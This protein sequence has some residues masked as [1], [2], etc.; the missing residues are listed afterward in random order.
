MW[1]CLILTSLVLLIAGGVV[2]VYLAW[3]YFVNEGEEAVS[4]PTSTPATPTAPTPTPTPR[5]TATPIPTPTP[6]PFPL[7]PG[8]QSPATDRE[9]LVRLYEA[10]D[11]PNWTDNRNWLS[12]A[13]L[14][15][16][17]GVDTDSDDRVTLLYL[18][19]NNLN[20][21]V[22][23]NLLNMGRLDS[24]LLEGNP[25]SGCISE[26]LQAAVYDDDLHT[27]G[28][29]MCSVVPTPV[30]S[31]TPI[32]TPT[33]VP[34]ATPIPTPTPVPTPTPIPTPKPTSTPVPTATPRPCSD[35]IECLRAHA[36][37]LINDDRARYGLQ[38]VALGSNIAAQLHAQDMVEH[39]YIGHW[40][41]DGRKPYMVYTQTGG[42]SYASENAAFSGWTDHRWEAQNCDSSRV[43]CNRGDTKQ[44]ITEHQWGMMYDDAHADWGHRDNILRESH[45]A[46]NI[47]IFWN[48]KRIAFV[49][50]FEGGAVTALSG[51]A[52]SRNGIFSLELVK[53]EQ[54]IHIGQGVSVYYD[55]PPT[56][57][58][59][60]QID[61]LDS[62]C[63]GGG[64]T[65][66]C[67]DP[68]IR[69]LRPP[70]ANRYYSNLDDNEVVAD[71]W[72][73]TDNSFSFSVDVSDL[74]QKPGVYTVIVWRDSGGSLLSEQ[75]I[76]LSVFV[77]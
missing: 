54:G 67:G 61:V 75:L 42:T 60:A 6:L 7:P 12:D 36:L 69:I 76:E 19:D 9:A 1:R 32:P 65:T 29:P 26:E 64:Q 33:P 72:T 35:D 56:R 14:V 77:R 5:P 40:W 21:V 46:V 28:L 22:P 39:G 2:G 45:R 27:L 70:G 59:V 24:L 47:G 68:V 52:L 43:R 18:I 17:Y 66:R 62:Y 71:S 13:P 48:K 37:R 8:V 31:P 49:Q 57:M 38:P 74:V 4:S 44:T 73:E 41:L 3:P 30:P 55:P 63:V 16:W 10:T 23:T 53:R 25:L 15:E 50:H 51:P 11:G 58:S 34:T 20:G